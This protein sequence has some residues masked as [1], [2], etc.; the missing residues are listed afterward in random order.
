MLKKLSPAVVSG[1]RQGGLG[2]PI[3]QEKFP[4]A[5]RDFAS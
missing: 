1:K 2:L 3:E 4:P 5:L